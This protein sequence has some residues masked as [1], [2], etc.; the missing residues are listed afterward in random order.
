M[1]ALY[2]AGIR[3]LV[4]RGIEGSIEEI[5]TNVVRQHMRKSALKP[6]AARAKDGSK[7]KV[8]KL[9]GSGTPVRGGTF[10]DLPWATEA[11]TEAIIDLSDTYSSDEI[12]QKLG[13]SRETI[14][15]WRKEGRLLG[16]ERAQRGVRYPK[17]QIGPNFAPLPVH[18]IV[19]ALGGDHWSAWRFLAAPVPELGGAT[20][21]ALLRAGK[22][23]MLKQVLAAR[24][25]GAFS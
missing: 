1:K 16:V 2:Q 12:G 24:D 17:Q 10:A 6:K 9:I 11:E 13:A 7:E 14:N 4:R 25:H 23:E 20:G 8:A 18:E 3:I 22:T 5:I 15:A 19:T 21:F